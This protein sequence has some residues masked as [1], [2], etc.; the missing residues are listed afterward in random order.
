MLL[1]A[2][3]KHQFFSVFK[4]ASCKAILC[5]KM[6]LTYLRNLLSFESY[7]CGLLSKVSCSQ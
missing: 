1:V 4:F 5:I 7:D 6:L 2:P 3:S